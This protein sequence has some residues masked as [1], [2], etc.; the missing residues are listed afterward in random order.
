MPKVGVM[1]KAIFDATGM[2]V[3]G[4]KATGSLDPDFLAVYT[5]LPVE[6]VQDVLSVMNKISPWSEEDRTDVLN[7]LENLPNDPPI[8]N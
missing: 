2:V 8:E 7:A 5:G 6:F 3:V 4:A 1:P